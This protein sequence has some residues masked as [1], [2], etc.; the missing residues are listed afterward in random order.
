MMEATIGFSDPKVH[1]P[2]LCCELMEIGHL[3]LIAIHTKL[4]GLLLFDS[5]Y[6]KLSMLFPIFPLAFAVTVHPPE[7]PAAVFQFV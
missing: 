1:E 3:F 2:K 7:A 5:V 4:V 6:A